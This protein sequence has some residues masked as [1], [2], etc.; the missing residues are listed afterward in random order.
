[1]YFNF[2]KSILN[3]KYLN[4]YGYLNVNS[5]NNNNSVQLIVTEAEAY[6]ED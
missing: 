4:F 3:N 1:M 5:F 2:D 6:K